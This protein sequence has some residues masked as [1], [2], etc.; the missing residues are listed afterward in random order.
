MRKATCVSAQNYV[1]WLNSR[2]GSV[3]GEYR[4]VWFN[5]WK[6]INPFGWSYVWGNFDYP[7][8]RC[9]KTPRIPYEKNEKRFFADSSI[10]G[11]HGLCSNVREFVMPGVRKSTPKDKTT[12]GKKPPKKTGSAGKKLL[13]V[14]AC[15]G[16]FNSQNPGDYKFFMYEKLPMHTTAQDI[17]FRVIFEPS[18]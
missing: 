3:P 4:L 18:Q 11:M 5:D 12:N 16:S 13:Y 1:D 7:L 8:F 6:R 2:K 14:L 9:P 17:G 15:A 10:F